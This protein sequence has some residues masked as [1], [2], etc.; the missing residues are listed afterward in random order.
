MTLNNQLIGRFLTVST[1]T[2]RDM[3]NEIECLLDRLEPIEAL[4]GFILEE[5][6]GPALFLDVSRSLN[7][8]GITKRA[9]NDG[10]DDYR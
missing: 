6:T 2:K 5:A 9:G 3:R 10:D 7:L 1:V 4:V 8:V